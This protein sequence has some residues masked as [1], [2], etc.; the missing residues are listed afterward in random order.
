[1]VWTMSCVKVWAWA[2]ASKNNTVERMTELEACWR[3]GALDDSMR[4][5]VI[6]MK[7]GFKASDL[8]WVLVP[9]DGVGAFASSSVD[10]HGHIQ[11]ELTNAQ[12]ES[13]HAAFKEW[14]KVLSIE[15]S[16]FKLWKTEAEAWDSSCAVKLQK[17]RNQRAGIKEADVKELCESIYNAHGFEKREGVETWIASQLMRIADMHLARPQSQIPRLLYV[18]MAALGV[19]HSRQLP[20]L[21]S[22]IK[23]GCDHHPEVFSAIVILPNTPVYGKGF[24]ADGIRDKNVASAVKDTQFLNIV[25]LIT[26]NVTC[27]RI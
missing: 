15:E 26:F 7:P 27:V 24:K 6:L 4:D 9:C 8:P 20:D 25:S 22:M 14:L 16:R 11:E 12:K 17:W 2:I 10:P 21:V 19:H 5:H 23:G 3:R 1:M 18:D 13:L